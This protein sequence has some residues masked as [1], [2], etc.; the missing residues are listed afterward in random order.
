MP[1]QRTAIFE[2]AVCIV[3]LQCILLICVRFSI[4][5]SVTIGLMA[6]YNISSNS[7]VV[8]A[9]YYISAALL[10]KEKVLSSQLLPGRS[11]DFV[12]NATT[13]NEATSLQVFASQWK[14]GVKAFIGPGC[15][16]ET[17][18]R[19]ASALNVPLISQLCTNDVLSDK[20][21]FSTFA[22]TIPANSR[23]APPLLKLLQ[24]YDWAWIGLVVEDSPEWRQR[25]QAMHTYLT[26]HGVTVAVQK[27]IQSASLYTTANDGAGF[28]KVLRSM[29]DDVRIFVFA[30]DYRLGREGVAYAKRLGLRIT[31]YAFILFAL[32]HGTV[33]NNVASPRKWF[34]G[35]YPGDTQ[36][37]S[38]ASVME[39][40]L[41]VSVNP[42]RT[43][44]YDQ[45]VASLKSR[46]NEAPFYSTVYEG[47]GWSKEPPIQGAYLYDAIVQFA[48][49]VNRSLAS[50]ASIS[51]GK[52]VM[53]KLHNT[54]YTSITGYDRYIDSN[55]DVDFDLVLMDYRQTPTESFIVIGRFGV[56]SRGDH[57]IKMNGTV[58]WPGN[59]PPKD[60]RKRGKNITIALLVP[61]NMTGGYDAASGAAGKFH[62]AAI[63]V[64]VDRI[65]NESKLLPG[66][67]LSFVWSDTRCDEQRSID[68]MLEFIE[69]RVDVIMGL[70]CQ[71]S[72]QARIAAA[73]NLPL[74]SHLCKDE[75]VSNKALYP[76]FARTIP[77]DGAI[78]PSVQALL[79]F[80]GWNTVGII[81]EN[82]QTFKSRGVFL[83]KF[84]MQKGKNVTF[85]GDAPMSVMYVPRKFE[86]QMKNTLME[87]QR[88]ARGKKCNNLTWG[89]GGGY[90][91]YLSSGTLKVKAGAEGGGRR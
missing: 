33:W 32:D 22:R 31:D 67:H 70:A 66:H 35:E 43:S 58:R 2:R 84:L 24:L 14:S 26:L 30:M 69:K 42:N 89:G 81:V 71:C 56:N 57:V 10:A 79:D 17:Q 5:E 39:A 87:A 18:A 51:D 49:A 21:D 50:G 80:F 73:V 64:T 76:T 20:K 82:S 40:V 25:A 59:Q 36:G 23:L 72:I 13:C 41:L 1:T 78:G 44:Q 37:Q 45:F 61:Y 11:F 77:A 74:I 38:F 28:E 19:V 6:P 53:S 34:C 83:E 75:K 48:I 27:T 68:Q 7:S 90:G 85:R 16:C 47:A 4:S 86:T 62:A 54:S 29:R 63:S 3:T 12:W 9:E 88:K 65:N 60:R 46:S 8:S 91:E 55:G 52:L 15:S